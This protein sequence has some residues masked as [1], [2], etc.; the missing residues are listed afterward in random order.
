MHVVLPES[1]STNI[2][3]YGYFEECVCLS[4]LR[5]LGD[6]MTFIDIGA[7]FGFFALLGRYLVG[8]K[9][10]VLAFE[11]TPSTYELLQKNMAKRHNVRVFNCAA[12]SQETELKFYD[13]GLEDSAYN[14]AFG[15]RK[16]DRSSAIKSTIIVKA[17][18]LDA[19][20]REIE[21]RNIDL[22]KIDA[23]SSELHVIKGMIE[24]LKAYKPNIIVEVGD[25][26]IE[27]VPN[28]LEIITLLHSMDYSPFEVHNSKM[29]SH[30][31]ADHYKYGNLLFVNNH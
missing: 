24:T 8:K 25:F 2:W 13:Y 27:G 14:S 22:I 6:G 20:L 29:V 19:I 16:A 3:R 12:Y 7:H 18:R 10:T 15:A 17:R 26:A 4:L 11:P 1:V 21:T 9:G 5:F 28:S 30:V 31:I 23:E